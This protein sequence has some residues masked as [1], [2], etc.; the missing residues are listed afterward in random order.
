MEAPRYKSRKQQ[1]KHESKK[2]QAAHN[3][4][5]KGDNDKPRQKKWEAA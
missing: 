4:Q 3:K 2:R 1:K 5:V